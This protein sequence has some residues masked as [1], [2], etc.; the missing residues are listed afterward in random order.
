MRID[1][2]DKNPP[3]DKIVRKILSI[4]E[5]FA[6]ALGQEGVPKDNGFYP[7][8]QWALVKEV[9]FY[10]KSVGDNNVKREVLV[11]FESEGSK[12]VI[13]FLLYSPIIGLPKGCSVHYMAVKGS[14]QEKGIG[15]GLLRRLINL[16]PLVELTCFPSKVGFYEK[17]GLIPFDTQGTQVVMS[18]IGKSLPG[19]IS[20]LDRQNIISS[21]QAQPIESII[22]ERLGQNGCAQASDQIINL[23]TK[24]TEEAKIFMCEKNGSAEEYSKL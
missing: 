7:L 19:N 12:E 4:V 2:F 8:Y 6:F 14:F 11:A 3:H 9:E 16:Y 5:K 18:T 17:V 13:G 1:I 15:A 24:L 22:K 23:Y 20:I 10:L 21:P